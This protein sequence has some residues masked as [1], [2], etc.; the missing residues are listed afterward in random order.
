MNF[1]LIGLLVVG[2]EH[3]P[4][5]HG[6]VLQVN[7]LDIHFSAVHN[8]ADSLPG[9]LLDKLYHEYLNSD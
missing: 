5:A 7:K 3:L 9:L 2:L 6:G 1:D 4:K 8:N